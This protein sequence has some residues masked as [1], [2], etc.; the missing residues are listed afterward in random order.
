MEAAYRCTRYLLPVFPNHKHFLGLH[1]RSPAQ[2]L[3]NPPSPD[4]WTQHFTW[5]V[6]RHARCVPAIDGA[7]PASRLLL[8]L[9][10][11]VKGEGGRDNVTDGRAAHSWEWFNVSS[12]IIIRLQIAFGK[13]LYAAKFPGLV[14]F[15]G[16]G[17]WVCACCCVSTLAPPPACSFLP[18][19][20][21]GVFRAARCF[22]AA[23]RYVIL[24]LRVS[25]LLA[26]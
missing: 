21:V 23:F 4:I 26:A 13:L 16:S 10:S 17:V 15:P 5:R 7:A 20:G 8:Q 3:P 14:V 2:T 1:A 25:I 6:L 9:Q 11:R 22:G 12:T 19:S 24:L 18:G